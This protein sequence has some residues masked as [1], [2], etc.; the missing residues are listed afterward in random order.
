VQHLVDDCSIQKMMTCSVI[1]F[2]GKDP[3]APPTAAA[4]RSA[5]AATTT[6]GSK[7]MVNSAV[8]PL[9]KAA[10]AKFT[11]QYPDM[12]IMDLVKKGGIRL[13]DVQVGGESASTTASSDVAP[14]A[15]TAMLCAR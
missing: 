10:V 8:P 15:D 1:A 6:T 3:D 2:L 12:L 9:C 13:S 7:P 14:D 4:A 11:K 5:K